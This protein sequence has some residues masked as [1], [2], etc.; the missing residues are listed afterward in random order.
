MKQTGL[1]RGVAVCLMSLVFVPQLALAAYVP[2]LPAIGR[3]FG[4]GPGSTSGSLVG[5]MAAYAVCMIL[6]GNLA[7]RYGSRRVQLTGLAVF[8]G[9]SLLCLL[10]PGYGV[11]VVGRVLQALGAGTGTV[12]SRLWVQ[13]TLPAEQRLPMLTAL[14]TVIA[15]TPAASPPLAG[16]AVE[17]TSWR[18]LFAFMAVLGAVIIVAVV[19]LLPADHG[20]AAEAAGT[21]AGPVR[22][23]GGLAGLGRAYRTVL[24]NRDF[25]VFAG[26]ISLAWCT[27]FTFTT[28]SSD[29]LQLRLGASPTLYGALYTLVITGY[30]AGSTTAKRLGRTRSLEFIARTAAAVAMGA[31]LLMTVT[32]RLWPH[33]T[34]SIVLPMAVCMLGVGA[35]FPTCQAGMMRYE[36]EYA[37]AASGL[38]FFLQMASGAC[39]T[40]LT[41]IPGS[42][43]SSMLAFAIALP[44]LSLFLL[45]VFALRSRSSRVPAGHD[46]A[47]AVESAV[48]PLRSG[49]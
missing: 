6:T 7:D 35:L 45:C 4:V 2:A 36:G 15:V 29:L 33:S 11:F 9:A 28:Y 5:Y 16:L 44:A 25:T 19:K 20:A 49:R 30:V 39:Y 32:V 24:A 17:H 8:T 46:A 3:S 18:A 10:A 12:I 26:A 14:S 34:L 42:P 21:P 40:A 48:R 41:G 31:A 27:Y 37:G 47:V 43:D 1:P 13:R 23:P 22:P 38:F